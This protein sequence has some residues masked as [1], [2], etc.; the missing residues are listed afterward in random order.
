LRRITLI[1]TTPDSAV[2]LPK[3]GKAYENREDRDTRRFQVN[4]SNYIETP[5][6]RV[7]E[8]DL[9]WKDEN[10]DATI[11]VGRHED[12][13]VLRYVPEQNGPYPWR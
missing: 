12:L 2:K 10:G 8:T 6:R 7:I 11:P 9:K 1:P 5:L 4:P 13:E 3:S